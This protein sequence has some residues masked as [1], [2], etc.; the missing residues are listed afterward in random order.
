MKRMFI[1]FIV[2]SATL[3]PAYAFSEDNHEFCATMSKLASAAMGMRQAGVEVVDAMSTAE[4]DIGR[5]MIID[6]YSKPVY[7]TETMQERSKSEFATEYYIYCMKNL[8]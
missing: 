5:H 4:S 6:A 1:A 3:S 8:D 7:Y 2:C